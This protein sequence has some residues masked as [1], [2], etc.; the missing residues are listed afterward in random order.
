MRPMILC[1]LMLTAGAA[2]AAPAAAQTATSEVVIEGSHDAKVTVVYDHEIPNLPGKS[3]R[4]VL[5]E[6]GPGGSSVAHT[7]PRSA[8]IYATVLEGAI[9]SKVNDGPETVYR[10]GENWTELPGDHHA[11]S[12]NASSTERARLLAVFVLDTGETELV[13]P[14]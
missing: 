10:A 8:L 13:T 14:Y 7:H 9:A 4:G 1:A 11:V 12:K 2:G 5:V 6:Y 3:V